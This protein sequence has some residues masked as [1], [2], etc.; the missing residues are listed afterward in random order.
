MKKHLKIPSL[1]TALA[2]LLCCF[3]A[4]RG[5]DKVV[6]GMITTE[7][8][9]L[10]DGSYNQG[11]YEG[12]MMYAERHN[13]TYKVYPP[14]SKSEDDYLKAIAAAVKDGVQICVTPGFNF[15]TTIFTAQD[16]YPDTNFVLIDGIP[17]NG[18]PDGARV[19]RI[20]PNTYSIL[21]AE[22]QAGFLAGYAIVA[23]GFRCLGFLGGRAYPAVVNYGYGFV[24]GAEFAAKELGL[25]PGEVTIRYDYAGTFEPSPEVQAKASSWY[26]DGIEVIFACGGGIGISVIH[27]STM[28][29][30]RWTIGV[31]ADQSGES[32]TVITSAMKMIANAVNYAI[33]A[34]FSGAFPG[35]QSDVLRADANGVGLSMDTSRFRSFQ[36]ADYDRIFDI[37]SK[38]LDNV[39]SSIITD[40]NIAAEDLPC[41]YVKVN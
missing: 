16:Q 25:Q 20:A 37:I 4:C 28:Y 19:E 7:K 12:I 17:N 32:G 30:G 10:E 22:E 11:T 31:D 24:Q 15:E 14:D 1:L 35:G 27:T 38:D 13:V 40:I 9:M 29:D 8:S 41:V 34:H 3:S 18:E 33:E 21:F 36:R 5:G 39:A 23:D 6:I 2:L 26:N